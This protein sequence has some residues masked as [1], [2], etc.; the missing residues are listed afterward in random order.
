MS[1]S[2][3]KRPSQEW[4]NRAKKCIAQGALTN[5]KNPS[6]HIRGIYPTHITHGNGC[7]LF[8]TDGRKYVDFVC[9]LGANLFGYGNPQISDAVRRCLSK[10]ISHSWPTTTEVETAED[11]QKLFPFIERMKF[12]KTG[13][14]VCMAA[15]RIARA[16]TGRTIVLSEGYHGH[17]DPFISMTPPAYGVPKDPNMVAFTSI[18]QITTDVAALILEPVSIDSS[19]QR[20]AYLAELRDACT[21]TGVVLIFDEII[22]G[23]RYS[24]NCVSKASGVIPDLICLGKSLAGGM[25]LSLVGGSAKIMETENSYFVSSTFAG[26]IAS[27]TAC[28][29]VLAMLRDKKNWNIEDLW[30][31]GQDFLEQFN[32]IHPAVQIKG[33]PTR[34]AFVGDPV[35]K[36]IFFQEAC[37]A[38]I[39][40]GPSWFFNWDLAKQTHSVMSTCRDVI[41]RVTRGECKLEGEMPVSPFAAKV[42]KL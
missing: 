5:S 21:K 10:G 37:R 38:G 13:T 25:P 17:S 8:D 33:Y 27:L 6:S 35:V 22:T 7:L 14:E 42:R 41:G 39:L 11:I 31:K 23:L 18:D 12:L 2:D 32:A 4:N 20:M 26:E 28:R 40:F 16:H 1:F 34:G 9:G 30:G 24:G 3:V 36:A 19:S 15:I 29:E